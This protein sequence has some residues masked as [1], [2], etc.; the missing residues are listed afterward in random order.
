MGDQN[1]F[2]CMEDALKISILGCSLFFSSEAFSCYLVIRLP[3]AVM[4]P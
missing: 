3:S 4:A 1:R 2:A